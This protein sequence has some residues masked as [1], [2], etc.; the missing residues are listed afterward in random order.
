MYVSKKDFFKQKKIFLAIF[1]AIFQA[2][3]LNNFF[4]NCTAC[5]LNMPKKNENLVS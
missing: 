5:T 2:R 4:S 3:V 1:Q